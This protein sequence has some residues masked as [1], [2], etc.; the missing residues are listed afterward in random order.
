MNLG[1]TQAATFRS[2]DGRYLYVIGGGQSNMERL[3]LTRVDSS[4]EI[5]DIELPDPLTRGSLAT[6]PIWNYPKLKL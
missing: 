6:F 2:K 4:W 3:D 5:I 1:R